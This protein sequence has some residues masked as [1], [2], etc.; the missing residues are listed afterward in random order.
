MHGAT[1]SQGG[2]GAKGAEGATGAW[3]DTG[4]KGEHGVTG[5]TGAQ[6]ATGQ[7][8]VRGITGSTGFKG[9]KGEQGE[10][11]AHGAKGTQGATGHKGQHGY[12]GAQGST[13]HKGVLGAKGYKGQK[14]AHGAV[15]AT[16]GKGEKG[17]VYTTTTTTIAPP[18]TPLYETGMTKENPGDSCLD[19]FANYQ[20]TVNGQYWIRQDKPVLPI[21]SSYCGAGSGACYEYIGRFHGR[22]RSDGTGGWG[23]EMAPMSKIWDGDDASAAAASITAWS[24]TRSTNPA[25]IRFDFQALQNFPV[26]IKYGVNGFHSRA[27]LKIYA[28]G[29]MKVSRDFGPVN[30]YNDEVH[31]ITVQDFQT[32][33]F[34]LSGDI[35]GLGPHPNFKIYEIYAKGN[36]Q[37]NSGKEEV[38]KTCDFRP[39]RTPEF[40]GE[41]C[42]DLKVTHNVV[43]SGHYFVKHKNH[44][45]PIP[46]YNMQTFYGYEIYHVWDK[47]LA[48]S[49]HGTIT[50]STGYVRFDYG[51]K[52]NFPVTVRYGVNTSPDAKIT[53]KIDDVVQP[54]FP[55]DFPMNSALPWN[56]TNLMISDF[57]TIT[58]VLDGKVTSWPPPKLKVFEIYP[59]DNLPGHDNTVIRN[60]FCDF[61]S[62]SVISAAAA[63][64]DV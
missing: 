23:N 44:K 18:P 5:E 60:K 58:F 2:T 39:G 27:N 41:N 62:P 6:G 9:Y 16:G 4:A 28:D 59:T 12:Q 56:T 25:G 20:A 36:L 22:A 31:E 35:S 11:G 32:L 51:E 43:D 30:S 19:L 34:M 50:T 13:G 63:A 64:A 55:R 29:V 24:V 48:S 17:D 49:F 33:K 61:G 8:G 47:I 45:L 3:G 40:A 54:G 14:G 53:I 15:G 26:I 1:G 38:L 57:Q 21:P 10:G 52:Q 42:T 7:K 46:T 37:R